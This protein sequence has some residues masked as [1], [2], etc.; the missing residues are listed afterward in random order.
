M[1]WITDALGEFIGQML[2]QSG[3]AIGDH[4]ARRLRRK[5]PGP[6]E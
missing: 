1:S 4:G 5:Q 3:H 2:V 6:N